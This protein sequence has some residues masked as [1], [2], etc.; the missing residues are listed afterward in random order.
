MKGTFRLHSLEMVPLINNFQYI[1][2]KNQYNF[3]TAG[4][5]LRNF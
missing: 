3:F 1:S 2:K 4:Y 5:K